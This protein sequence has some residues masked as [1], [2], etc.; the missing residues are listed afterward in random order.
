MSFN[1]ISRKLHTQILPFNYSHIIKAYSLDR[2]RFENSKVKMSTYSEYIFKSP[3]ERKS[4]IKDLIE[5]GWIECSEKDA[6]KKTFNFKNFVSAFSFMTSI[7]LEAEKLDHHPEWFN[8][9]NRVD[10]TLNSHFC[11]GVSKMDVK[12]ARIIEA[13]DVKSSK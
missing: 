3:D 4:H 7:A 10:I 11:S 8:V 5:K 2:V 12:L 9:Y 1:L 13:H 6:I